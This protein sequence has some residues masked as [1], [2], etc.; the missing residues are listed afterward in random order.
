MEGIKM[1]CR[2]GHDL[3]DPKSHYIINRPN[4]NGK[5]Y[6]TKQCRKCKEVGRLSRIGLAKAPAFFE[7]EEYITVNEII[8]LQTRLEVENL[9]RW[10]QEPIKRTI[11]KL[12][13][14]KDSYARARTQSLGKSK[15]ARANGPTHGARH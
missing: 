9:P 15:K 14:L 11:E 3:S 13:R 5:T 6:R 12:I 7:T 4:K 8:R 2:H 10:E 1:R